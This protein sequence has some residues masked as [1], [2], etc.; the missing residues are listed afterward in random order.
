MT[1]A[2]PLDL[3]DLPAGLRLVVV[4]MDG[5]LLDGRGEVPD[6]LW[7][8]LERLRSAGVA[9]APASGRQYATL[10]RTF[11]RARDGMVFIAENGTMVVRDGVELS[12]TTLER[13]VVTGVVAAVRR[14]VAAGADVGVVL[15]G[16]RTA[17]VERTDEAFLAEVRRYYAALEVVDDLDAVDD[18]FVKVAVH[19][20]DGTDPVEAALAGLRATHQ[21]VVSG[22]H[23]VDVMPAGVTKGDAV[24]RLQDE[25]G[26]GPEHTVAF[27]DYLNDLEMLDAAE[28]SFA[29]A[30]AHP[31]VRR[32]ARHLAPSHTEAGVLTVVT[33]LLDRADAAG[34]TGTAGVPGTA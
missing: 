11:E 20:A 31:E 9:F 10:A 17:Y 7:P 14:V 25:L 33:A 12:S 6:G 4:D 34:P 3:P 22:A 26:I 28:G 8:L 29:M 24:R 13:E 5:T 32:R 2:Q 19:A 23:W 27:G 18:A 16:K 30:E 21:V 15:C 1:T